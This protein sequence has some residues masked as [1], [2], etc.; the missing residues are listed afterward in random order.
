MIWPPD[1]LLSA[2]VP[3]QLSFRSHVYTS[4]AG[5]NM[6]ETR[7]LTKRYEDSL[8]ALDSLT[9]TVGEGQIYCLLGANGAGK[10]TTI[11]LILGFIAPTSG[12]ALLSGIDV[13]KDG[14]AS[15]EHVAYVSEN[16][17]LY[18]AFSAR[19]NLQYF[20]RLGGRRGLTR[21]DYHRCLHDV[22]LPEGAFERPMRTL[23]KGMRQKVGLAIAVVKD[24]DNILLDEPTSGLDPKA[25]AEFVT[26]VK[27]LRDQGKSILM[28]THDI[29]RAR[30]LA[31]R[32]GIMKDGSLIMDRSR[33]EFGKE[34]LTQLYLEYM[35]E[36]EEL[37]SLG[38]GAT[39]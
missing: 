6:I 10:S 36:R 22:G 34:D 12:T 33:D 17:M 7:S 2:M 4:R 8:L 14:L 5:R 15:R 25:A 21:G 30:E 3:Q 11:N 13:V 16:V 19:Q 39:T 18:G 32:M 35:R 20:A 28:S 9:L 27:R 31:D 23:S 1:T 24:A 37:H 29:F 26:L 38:P